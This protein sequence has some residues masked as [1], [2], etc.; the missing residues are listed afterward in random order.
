MCKQGKARRRGKANEYG[1][2]GKLRKL[3]TPDAERVP[4]SG[5]LSQLPGDVSAPSLGTLFEAKVYALREVE[6]ARYARLELN[7]IE[8]IRQEA[9]RAGY[10]RGV[11]AFRGKGQRQTY[12][13][14]PLEDYVS[15]VREK[16]NE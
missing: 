9:A 10:A 6:G 13:I 8:K 12:V 1:L 14:L 5:A 3:G 16:E 4:L 11:V 15:L 2:V 7:W